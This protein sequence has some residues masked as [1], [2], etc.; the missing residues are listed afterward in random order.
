[1]TKE[2]IVK[3]I[4]KR[5]DENARELKDADEQENE[6]LADYHNGA[7]EALHNILVKIKLTEAV[8][9]S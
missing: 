2:E 6:S 8:N 5:K 9:E 3:L 4:E 7:Y 1:M